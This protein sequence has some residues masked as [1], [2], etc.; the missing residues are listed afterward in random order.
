MLSIDDGCEATESTSRF[1]TICSI[2]N[3][4]R[5]DLPAPT[6]RVSIPGE[7]PKP[8]F[9][10]SLLRCPLASSLANQLFGDPR[11][12]DCTMKMSDRRHRIAFSPLTISAVA[13]VVATLRTSPGGAG[14][15]ELP[16]SQTARYLPSISDM[17]IATIQ[18]RHRRLWRT[19]QQKNWAFAAYELGNLKGAFKRLGQA[20]PTEH[21]VAGARPISGKGDAIIA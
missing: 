11:K 2:K 13:A 1:F 20:H 7:F 5:I 12:C 17:M 4:F 18:P 14:A 19:A 3:A 15:Q 16:P 10:G 8:Q 9:S 6:N 21:E